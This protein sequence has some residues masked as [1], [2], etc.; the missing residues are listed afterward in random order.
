MVSQSTSASVHKPTKVVSV[1]KSDMDLHGLMHRY[2]EVHLE[3]WRPGAD[4]SW[5]QWEVWRDMATSEEV[6]ADL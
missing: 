3:D 1:W 6:G 2:R 5:Q 4:M